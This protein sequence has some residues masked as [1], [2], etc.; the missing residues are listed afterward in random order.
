MTT[1]T[2]DCWFVASIDE[3]NDVRLLKRSSRADDYI[4]DSAMFVED[5]VQKMTENM[6]DGVYRLSVNL[7]LLYEL[8]PSE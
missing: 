3:D 2:A 6:P 8:P 4:D 1:H 7:E 5:A